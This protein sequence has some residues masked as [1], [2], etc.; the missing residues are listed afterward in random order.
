[1]LNRIFTELYQTETIKKS[2]YK[3]LNTFLLKPSIAFFSTSLAIWQAVETS[4]SVK[5][6]IL[7]NNLNP[8]KI[9]E[10]STY[11]VIGSVVLFIG[12]LISLIIFQTTYLS[13]LLTYKK[14]KKHLKKLVEIDINDMTLH[15]MHEIGYGVNGEG[16]ASLDLM[17]TH[18]G[19]NKDGFRCWI[20]NTDI[21]NRNSL[22]AFFIIAPLNK[23]ATDRILNR[24]IRGASKIEAKMIVKK[25]KE[26]KSIYITEVYGNCYPYDAC[27]LILLFE[28]ITKWIDN[29]KNL[30]YL[31]A[32]PVSNFGT[33]HL[34]KN[35]FKQI[36]ASPTDIWIRK[37]GDLKTIKARWKEQ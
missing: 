5:N 18:Y 7:S 12:Y 21:M 35:G 17:K 4:D 33:T 9:I 24:D 20:S 30:E 31:F 13:T 1:M 8:E 6:T 28:E 26:A 16:F 23:L 19:A 15:R 25:F 22:M 10:L 27:A 11:V 14:V 37:V 34:Q 29:C 3:K 32:R 2:T 36:S